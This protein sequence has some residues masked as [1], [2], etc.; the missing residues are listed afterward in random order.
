MAD[1]GVDSLSQVSLTSDLAIAFS[2]RYRRSFAC[3]AILAALM[4]EAISEL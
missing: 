2:R 3:M 4:F 1:D